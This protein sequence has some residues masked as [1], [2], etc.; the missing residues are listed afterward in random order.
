GIPSAGLRRE[1]RRDPRRTRLHL[2][3]G[4]F[5]LA[6]NPGLVAQ[7]RKLCEGNGLLAAP[8]RTGVVAD[9]GSEAESDHPYR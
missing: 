4:M 7:V 6:M 1:F 5:L 9:A 3:G 2:P 8:F